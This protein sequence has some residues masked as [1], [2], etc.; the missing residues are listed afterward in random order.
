LHTA[1]ERGREECFEEDQDYQREW[2]LYPVW[3][4][5]T[6][7]SGRRVV[8]PQKAGNVPE[9]MGRS[10]CI[11]STGPSRGNGLRLGRTAGAA[12]HENHPF[13]DGHH[14]LGRRTRVASPR[15][16]NRTRGSTWNGRELLM[17][18]IG[19]IAAGALIVACSGG[20]I[21][22]TNAR[23]APPASTVG[24]APMQMMA[25]SANLPTEHFVDYSLVYP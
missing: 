20:W 22:S 24:I 10:A 8:E 21:A 16:R 9:L 11:G 5:A 14:I 19:F 2:L 7:S 15:V 18:K 17:R 4:S 3:G 13:C 23:V 25:A 12:R 1:W 6:S